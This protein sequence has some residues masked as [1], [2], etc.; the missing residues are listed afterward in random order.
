M[1]DSYIIYIVVTNRKIDKVP[2]LYNHMIKED[3]HLRFR[4][5]WPDAKERRVPIDKAPEEIIYEIDRTLEYK[6][7]NLGQ[8]Y[9]VGNYLYLVRDSSDGLEKVLKVASAPANAGE[10][11]K[12]QHEH[13]SLF[14]DNVR[15]HLK[16]SKNLLLRIILSSSHDAVKLI[17]GLFYEGP[18]KPTHRGW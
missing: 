12:A 5:L 7:K 4:E 1:Q 17:T 10:F 8:S 2:L 15:G 11:G 16:K 13:N 14:V 9:S 6:G 18:V 3:W